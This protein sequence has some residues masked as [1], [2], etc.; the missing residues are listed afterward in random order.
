MQM[1]GSAAF[2]YLAVSS[3]WT[4]NDPFVGKWKLDLSRSLVIDR[5]VI[6]AAGPNRYTFKFEGAPA[7]TVVA[8]GT[9]QP[10]LPGTTVSVKAEDPR[11]LKFV[12]KQEGR[13]IVSAAWKVSPDDRTLRDAF[14]AVL[15]DGSSSTTNYVYTRTAGA[16]G[17]VGAWE[18]ST[19]PASF[20]LQIQPFGSE[21]LSFVRQGSVRSV[22]FDGQDHA[23]GGPIKGLT[24]SGSR[25]SERAMEITQKIAGKGYDVRTYALSSDGRTLTLKVRRAGQAT[26]DVMVFERE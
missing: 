12:R 19:P 8:D 24:A 3:L 22:T 20:E 15:P 7:E 25:P 11:T 26:P 2:A 16:S 13:V 17:F 18:S 4:A 6:E 23:V 9:D 14:T 21:G 1:L 10:G 5:M